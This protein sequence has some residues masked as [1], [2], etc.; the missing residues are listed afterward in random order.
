[1]QPRR[2]SQA[3]KRSIER[4]ASN[5]RSKLD[6]MKNEF[7]LGGA[8]VLLDPNSAGLQTRTGSFGSRFLACSGQS[9]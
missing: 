5:D 9:S 1:M 7:L 6:L 8:A 2:P 4:L 3:I